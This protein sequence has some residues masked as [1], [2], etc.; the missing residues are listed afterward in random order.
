MAS[1][2]LLVGCL[3]LTLLHFLTL[4]P[5]YATGENG[6]RGF[7]MST[8]ANVGEQSWRQYVMLAVMSMTTG[9]VYMGV[10]FFSRDMRE[11]L[12]H[13]PAFLERVGRSTVV[14]RHVPVDE[15][16]SSMEEVRVR[17]DRYVRSA[18]PESKYAVVVAPDVSLRF[19]VQQELTEAR[20]SL[21][22]YETYGGT[23]RPSSLRFWHSVDGRLHFKQQVAV[24]EQRLADLEKQPLHFSG[25]VFVT[26]AT[27]QDAFEFWELHSRRSYR[28]EAALVP[29]AD[30][31]NVQKWRVRP[32]PDPDDILW[33]RSQASAARLL[34][35][36]AAVIGILVFLTTPV[37]VISALRD[38]A[39]LPGVATAIAD[40]ESWGGYF[41][42]FLLSIIPPLLILSISSFMPPVLRSITDMENHPS[43]SEVV[44]L[45]HTRAFIFLALN[46]L[47]L[48]G[49]VL[50]SFDVVVSVTIADPGDLLKLLGAMFTLHTGSYFVIYVINAGI[51]GNMWD[52]VAP[53]N[54]LLA[55][56]ND[57]MAKTPR[58]HRA[59]RRISGYRFSSEMASLGAIFLTVLTFSTASLFILPAGVVYF[60]IKYTIDKFALVHLEAHRQ[61]QDLQVFHRLRARIIWSSAFHAFSMSGLFVIKGAWPAGVVAFCVATTAAIAAHMTFKKRKLYTEE[62]QLLLEHA[63]NCAAR[64]VTEPEDAYLER[65]DCFAHPPVV[66]APAEQ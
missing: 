13:S 30:G 46:I 7:R 10:A 51:V 1:K 6:L 61:N 27:I 60:A 49:L 50:T 54:L 63:E 38:A 2:R 12:R 9:L 25:R 65:S 42:H 3:L 39:A 36:N 16:R 18:L 19:T 47:I 20:L 31:L 43:R 35:L 23:F 58:Q 22:D 66:G 11:T 59:A 57:K 28:K 14:I 17:I 37:A 34:L 8:L 24:L 21:G 55:H 32:A 45:T 52:L 48:P 62:Y 26:F 29:E 4:F 56:I 44:N 40:L 15:V 33:D 41:G 64:G 53:S 5:L